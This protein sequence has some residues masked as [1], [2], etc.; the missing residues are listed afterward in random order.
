MARHKEARERRV[1]CA[2]FRCVYISILVRGSKIHL[3]DIWHKLDS[4]LVVCWFH[5]LFLLHLI[6]VMKKQPIKS[7]M[8]K[9]K[10][11]KCLFFSAFKKW[12]IWLYFSL[13]LIFV[14]DFT[15][16]N[17]KLLHK[18]LF[19]NFYAFMHIFRW[20]LHHFVCFFFFCFCCSGYSSVPE[21][22]NL[23]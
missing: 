5:F 22:N 16:F 4:F 19:K 13:S 20:H 1:S 8:F 14:A 2:P 15:I 23:K 3:F 7:A 6:F 18:V 9:R 17:G 12:M 11:T 10:M 21:R